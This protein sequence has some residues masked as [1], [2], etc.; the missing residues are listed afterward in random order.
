[1]LG[2]CRACTDPGNPGSC[3]Y[4]YIYLFSYMN[5]TVHFLDSYSIVPRFC[6]G[7]LVMQPSGY[8]RYALY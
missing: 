8:E 3:V 5:N 4:T 2:D 7:L 1:M 6:L